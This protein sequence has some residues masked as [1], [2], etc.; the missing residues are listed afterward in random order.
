M[1]RSPVR[2]HPVRTLLLG[3]LLLILAYWGFA[4]TP[5]AGP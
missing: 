2:S 4:A 1:A 5:L 3:A